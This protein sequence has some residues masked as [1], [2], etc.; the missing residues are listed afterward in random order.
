MHKACG[1]TWVESLLV[2]LPPVWSGRL[3]S[4]RL[5]FAFT[6]HLSLTPCAPSLDPSCSEAWIEVPQGFTYHCW[7]FKSVQKP[8][9]SSAN[10]PCGW[11][12]Q[13]KSERKGNKTQ[14]IKHGVRVAYTLLSLTHIRTD[15]ISMQVILYSQND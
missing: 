13:L 11:A 5:L 12:G 1:Y 9:V 7:A 8:C 4:Q 6:V 14:N 10:V 15:L 3:K 2:L